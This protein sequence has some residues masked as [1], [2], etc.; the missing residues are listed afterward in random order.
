MAQLLEWVPSVLATAASDTPPDKI[1][2]LTK[3][4]KDGNHVEFHVREGIE[5]W[6][7]STKPLIVAEY[8]LVGRRS[9]KLPIE[10]KEL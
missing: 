8:K 10:V 1:F 7:T 5:D 4:D 9:V 6:A 3:D 2:V